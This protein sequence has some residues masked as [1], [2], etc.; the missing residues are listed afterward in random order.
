MMKKNFYKWHRIL[1][2]IALVPVICWCLSGVSHPFMSNWF[3][4]FI[5]Q[6]VFKPMSQLQMSPKLSLAEVMDTNKLSS[7]R[8]FGLV[9]FDQQTYY[10]LLM[11]D[12]TYRYY[13]AIDGYEK[14]NGD[15]LYAEYLA[16]YF[17]QDSISAIRHAQLQTTFDAHYQPINRL[18]PV[19]KISFDRADS[20]DI[21][22]ETAQSRLGTFNNRTRK[23]MLSFFQQLHTWEFLASVFGNTFRNVVMLTVVII[24]TF[25]LISGL[26]V[27]GLLWTRFKTIA[28]KRRESG[29]ADQRFVHRFHRQLGIIVSFVMLAFSVSGAFHLWVKLRNDRPAVKPFEQLIHRSELVKSNLELPVADSAI[30]RIGLVKF[31][32]RAYY[33][34][35]GKQKQITYM[36][37]QSGQILTDGDMTLATQL[38]NYYRQETVKPIKTEVIKQFTNEYGFINKRLPVVKVS[39]PK[40]EDLYIETTSAKLATRVAGMD[41]AEGLSFIILHKYFGMTWAGKDIR[42]IVSMLAAAGVLVVSL[43]GFAA[44]LKNK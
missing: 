26:V 38:A 20:M 32:G 22:V 41:R 1:G 10:Q 8:N 17:T 18:L 31:D 4:P 16:R 11:P 9:N 36:D 14:A 40:Q 5:P 7:V 25:S 15:R 43:F 34:V 27:Y 39:Y 30:K 12:S 23:A 21:Y 35:I 44:F 2:L 13:S 24:M 29:V 28:Q 33:Q 19:W 42:D 3:R 37:A 6:E